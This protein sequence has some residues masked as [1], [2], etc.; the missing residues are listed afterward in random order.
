MSRGRAWLWGWATG[1]RARDASRVPGAPQSEGR[2]VA[3]VGRG[4]GR[5]P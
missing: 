4:M 2:E 1:R 3:H 5:V